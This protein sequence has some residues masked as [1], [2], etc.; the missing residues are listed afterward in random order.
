MGKTTRLFYPA[1]VK[2]NTTYL[3]HVGQQ[4]GEFNLEDL[5]IHPA[6]DFAPNFVGSKSW[7]PEFSLQTQDI[8][9]ALDL[10][11][12]E[13][14]CRSMAAETAKL[15]FRAATAYGLQQAVG[16]AV[17]AVYQLQSDAL[18]YWDSLQVNQN[19]EAQ[20]SLKLVAADNQSNAIL[21]A[22]PSQT[23]DAAGVLEAPF[24][25]G[26]I[27]VNGTAVDGVKSFTW[28]NNVEVVKEASCG[29]ESPTFV[30]IR[31]VR[32]VIQFEAT[33]LQTFAGYDDDGEPL[34]TV[35]VWLR[36]R[37]PNKV[38]YDDSDSEHIKLEADGGGTG[39]YIGRLITRNV[40]G[41]PGRVQAEIHLVRYSTNSLFTYS[42][43]QQIT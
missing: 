43:D 38:N 9:K 32:P 29:N 8:E 12:T 5:T 1:G 2:L 15:Y 6:G 22:L 11:A 25:L 33:D 17:H 27:V 23:I 18:L 37:R 14:L 35:T 28:Q 41:D 36:R 31:R 13:A 20:L 39:Q 21:A 4:S 30:C 24:T 40:G 16:S 19:N 42:K 3:A 26:D 10:M 7:A 34:E